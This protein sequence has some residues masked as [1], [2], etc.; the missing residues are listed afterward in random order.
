MKLVTFVKEPEQQIG[1]LVNDDQDIVILQ[2]GN[3]AKEGQPTPFFSDML[4]FLRGGTAAR[5]IHLT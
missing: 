4:A 3:Q 5:D 1:A 2:A